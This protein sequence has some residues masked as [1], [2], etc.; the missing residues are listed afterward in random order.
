M[1]RQ[2]SNT[3]ERDTRMGGWVGV[4][5]EE[6]EVGRSFPPQD[7]PISAEDFTT[8][9]RC[10]GEDR[11]APDSNTRIPAFLLNELL[12]LKRQMRLPPGVLHAQE[13]LAMTS[14]ARFGEPLQTTVRIADKYIRND[15]RFVIVEQSVHC[16]TDNRSIMQIRH[17][18]YWPC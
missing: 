10:L 13:E 8:F 6:L 9:Y 16:A 12:A 15:K 3:P 4:G 5:Y 14:A 17:I 7:L 18:L 2:R 1:E 11:A